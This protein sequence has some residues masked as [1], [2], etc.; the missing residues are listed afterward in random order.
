MLLDEVVTKAHSAPHPAKNL[1]LDSPFQK[2]VRACREVPSPSKATVSD[3][4]QQH[5]PP[6]IAQRQVQ[7]RA[8]PKDQSPDQSFKQPIPPRRLGR[9]E[10]SKVKDCVVRCL[11]A[12][13]RDIISIE[14]AGY[15]A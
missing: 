13:G 3:F 15:P 2:V 12:E 1:L 7:P 9:S 8:Q 10:V 11:E 5:E 14:K 4:L 6:T